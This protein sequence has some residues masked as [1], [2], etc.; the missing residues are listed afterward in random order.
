MYSYKNILSKYLS[1]LRPKNIVEWGPGKSTH[2]ILSALDDIKLLSIEHDKNYFN[3]INMEIDDTRWSSLLVKNTNRA[4]RYAHI[5][6][7]YPP[8]DLYFIDGRRRVECAFSAMSHSPDS[9]LILH[10]CS[11]KMYTDILK[12]FVD[13]IEEKD[14]TLVFKCH[15]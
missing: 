3:K 14:D 7:D 9:T 12:P 10:D 5:I 1:E 4:S 6:R 2:L 13:I 11:R 15:L 8:A